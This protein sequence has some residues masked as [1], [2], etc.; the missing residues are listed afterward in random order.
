[1]SVAEKK[2]GLAGVAQSLGTAKFG[3][4]EAPLSEVIARLEAKDPSLVLLDTRSDE[5]RAVSTIPGS[6]GKAELEAAPESFKDKEI[7]TFC[8]VRCTP[9][10][11]RALA[12]LWPRAASARSHVAPH[13]TSS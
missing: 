9:E 4:A 6:I 7:V 10:R 8:T 1:M 11:L 5:E 2:E 12:A 3:V 13:A